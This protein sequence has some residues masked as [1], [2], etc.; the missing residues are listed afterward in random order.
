M[1]LGEYRFGT[2]SN[3]ILKHFIY[4]FHSRI[5]NGKELNIAAESWKYEGGTTE[6]QAL[7]IRNSSSRDL[8]SFACKLANSVGSSF[9]PTSVYV[10]VH[11]KYLMNDIN[12][13]I[14]IDS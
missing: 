3:S 12:K 5:Q 13:R 1:S 9:S 6:Q 4:T 14:R 10:D 7:L 11:C 2:H 8:G